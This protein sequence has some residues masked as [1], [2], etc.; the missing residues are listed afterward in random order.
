VKNT[1]GRYVG[2]STVWALLLLTLAVA[3]MTEGS[4]LPSPQWPNEPPGFNVVTDFPF[5]A[6]PPANTREPLNGWRLAFSYGTTNIVN[7]A[8]APLSPRKSWN[9][10]ALLQ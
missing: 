5:T 7:D 3:L 2:T 4:A 6:L 9:L 1:V 8:L 10:L